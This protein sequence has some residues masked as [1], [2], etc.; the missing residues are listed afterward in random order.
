[1]TRALR[2]SALFAMGLLV[3]S[4]FVAA[5][6]PP[7]STVGGEVSISLLGRSNVSSSKFDEYRE[8]PNGVSIPSVN[9]FAWKGNNGFTLWG[10][11]VRQGDQRWS[12]VAG[13]GFLGMSFDYNRTPHNMG[14][15]G[16]VL[17]NETSL[18]A[19]SMDTVT[20]AALG[21]KIDTT[22]P[23]SLRT[24]DF[25][26]TLLQPV[27]A[28]TN[29]VDISSLRER[30]SVTFDIGKG[31]LP[32]DISMTYMRERKSGYRTNSGS[33]VYTA[34][35]TIVDVPEPLSDLVQDYG[36]RFNYNFKAGNVHAG[37]NRNTFDNQAETL[38]ID[39]P[40]Q[41][42]DVAY[43]GVT[44]SPLGGPGSIRIINAPDNE[45]TTGSFGFLLKFKKQTRIGADV[46]MAQWTQNTAFYPYTIN[47]TVKNAAGIPA[48]TVAAL[49]TTSLNGKINTS[50][51]NVWATSKPIDN[52]SL[53]MRYRSYDMTNKTPRFVIT[54]D[55]A[56]SPDRTWSTVTASTSAPW[57]HATADLYDT[58]SK[59][60][61]LNANYDLK[62]VTLE[63][64]FFNNSLTRTNREAETGRDRGYGFAAVYHA[65]DVVGVRAFTSQAKRTANGTTVNGFQE[66]EAERT[67]TSSGVDIEITPITGLGVTFAYARQKVDY[68]NR[69]L[70]VA[71]D[72]NT[73][74]GL[75]WT[76]YDTFTGEIEINPNPRVELNAF[77]TYEKNGQTNRWTTVTGGAVG[78]MLNYEGTDKG[79]TFGV[80][81]VFQLVP[82]KYTLS[83]LGSQQKIDGLMDITASPSTGSFYAARA[84][85]GGPQPITDWDDTTLTTFNLQL[86]RKVT[87][88]WTFGIGYTYE[89][90]DYADAY[91]SGTTM[92]PTSLYIYMKPDY[93]AYKVNIGYAKLTYKF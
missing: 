65:S 74:S 48:N 45:A 4:S 76:K 83:V 10:D 82:E 81:G 77:Y 62:G 38:V 59:R 37:L 61:D 11:N 57:G 12:G 64:S 26:N 9:L 56:T 88:A 87:K 17:W 19:W 34:V 69:P 85:L 86:D 47:S 15:G 42:Y 75:L 31:K 41:P 32:F 2:V 70:R 53:R 46:S 89:K 29:T 93:G 1:M 27:F 60:F 84:A 25:Y 50:T 20:R 73:V 54:G 49:Q 6:E 63:G 67:R 13:L 79:N 90:Y 58:T 33:G 5:Q 16:H 52:L 7:A 35:T 14:N 66:D 40:F 91:T 78:N 8:T 71:A 24:F 39:S 18:G 36:F 3:A 55:V 30:G 80:N 22:L 68:T 43:N 21:T 28:A 92:M 51:V 23:T 44:A 72:P